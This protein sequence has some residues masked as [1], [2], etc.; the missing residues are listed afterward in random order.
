MYLLLYFIY[1]SSSEH[2][3][4]T[5]QFK[6][7]R[8]DWSLDQK[9]RDLYTPILQQLHWLPVKKRI[10]FKI[11]N[12]VFECLN[13]IAHLYLSNNIHEYIP[14]RP[15]RSSNALNQI[16]PKTKTKFGK[17]S[18]SILDLF[19]GT[20]YHD[21]SCQPPVRLKHLRVNS[22]LKES[23]FKTINSKLGPGLHCF[24]NQ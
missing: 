2:I 17:R 14:I 1:Q 24:W 5:K 18:S 3:Q 4:V 23:N 15:L 6:I 9:K 11:L 21:I 10:W 13:N 16:V 20:R 12:L 22:Y 7:L 8:L 19:C